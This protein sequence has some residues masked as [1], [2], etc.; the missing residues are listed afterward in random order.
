MRLLAEVEKDGKTFLR[1]RRTLILLVAAPLIVLLV[2]AGVFGKATTEKALPTSIGLCDLDQ[3]EASALFVESVSSHSN[4]MDY[5]DEENCGNFVHSQ[6]SQGKLSA[7]IIIPK[8]FQEGIADG[9]SQNMT[10]FL[11]NSRVQIS[12][13][14]EAFLKAAAQGTGQEIGSGFILSVW[15]RLD[16]ASAQLDSI[17]VDV[18]AS[19]T[20]A[21]E[22]QASISET[23]SSLSSLDFTTLTTQLDAANSTLD[24]SVLQLQAAQSNLTVMQYKMESY[25]EELTQTEYDLLR[26]RA[27]LENASGSISNASA[28]IDCSN[29]IFIPYCISLASMNASVSSAISDVDLRISKINATRAELRGINSTMD[30]FRANIATSLSE[31]E[32][33]RARISTMYAFVSSLEESRE[34]S[35]STMRE[36]NSSAAQLVSKSDDLEVLILSSKAQIR[37]ITSRDAISVIAPILFSSENIFSSRTFFDFLLPSLIPLIL[38]F[39]SLFLASTSLVREKNSL[40]LERV[41]VAQVPLWEYA[42]TKIASYT[43]VLSPEVLLLLLTASLVYGAFPLTD[44]PLFIFLSAA[45]L[46]LL[47]AFNAL[48]IVIAAFSESEATAFLASLVIGLPLLFMSGILFPFEFMPAPIVLLGQAT[49]LTPAIIAMQ[50][51]ILYATPD[52]S[53]FITLIIYDIV[54]AVLAAGALYATKG[55]G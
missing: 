13:S 7:A 44:T 1:E 49:P 43:I 9:V 19:R 51:G 4:I 15:A 10:V 25:D 48:G 50:S 53:I 52:F 12:P 11:D 45:L 35:L 32:D 37:E 55:R 24:G 41:Y 54:L 31:T 3:S 14:V 40:T 5:S 42:F 23:Y 21:L 22:I 30:E 6:V 27:V 28:S 8:G 20:K 39:V 36:I 47:F 38:M 34:E 29:P 16:N 33:V 46:L 26:M 17:L 2:L 18:N